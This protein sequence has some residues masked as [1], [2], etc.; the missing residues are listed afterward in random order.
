MA[1]L[2]AEGLKNEEVAERLFISAHTA[3]RHTENV[4]GKLGLHS[5]KA[6]A[7]TLMQS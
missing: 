4:L 5:R 6:L 2:L 1:L 7:L 3:R